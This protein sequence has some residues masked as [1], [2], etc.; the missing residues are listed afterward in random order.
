[1]SSL[2][3]RYQEKFEASD[4][5][6][7]VAQNMH[8]FEKEHILSGAFLMD[9]CDHMQIKTL[10]GLLRPDNFRALLV[11]PSHD[12][13]GWSKAPWYGTEYH[14]EAL[15]SELV[16]RLANVELNPELSL[17]I[18]NP[19]IPHQFDV[20]MSLEDPCKVCL[21]LVLLNH[22]HRF[23]HVLGTTSPSKNYQRNT[24]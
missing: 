20:L 18:R 11:A 13:E 24:N 14:V 8:S 21:N 2:S 17:P 10:L 5:T 9:E 23:L 1:M 7:W 22:S 3:F 15:P 4:F 19:Y 16:E 6:S 12:T